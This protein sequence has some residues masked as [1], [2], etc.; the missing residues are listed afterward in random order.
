VA[1]CACGTV[2]A[3]AKRDCGCDAGAGRSQI[4]TT[5]AIDLSGVLPWLAAA[6][7]LARAPGRG[8]TRSV[9]SRDA[10]ASTADVNPAR[11]SPEARPRLPTG[12]AASKRMDL[13]LEAL[14][15]P[16]SRV[17][18][19]DLSAAG[20]ASRRFLGAVSE[21]WAKSV[22]AI[23][24]RHGLRPDLDLTGAAAGLRMAESLARQESQI[25]A[26]QRMLRGG[27]AR[28]RVR[29]RPVLLRCA[30]RRSAGD[31][32][33]EHAQAAKRSAFPR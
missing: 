13:A 23:S 30:G 11:S 25:R 24:R 6:N 15:L 32:E 8:L 5:V 7:T 31:R 4:E 10:G 12:E 19:L 16:R 29:D 28:A 27:R 20:R 22:V 21:S 3:A 17:A 9:E 1:A 2:G 18:E 26:A 33:P 14:D